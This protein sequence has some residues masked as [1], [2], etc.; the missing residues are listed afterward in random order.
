MFGNNGSRPQ[1]SRKKML[2]H[3]LG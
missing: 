3:M 1:V 2:L